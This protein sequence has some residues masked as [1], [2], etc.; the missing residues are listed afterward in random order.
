[1][2]RPW[3]AH[4]EPHV[5]KE[6]DP[7]WRRSIPHILEHSFEAFADRP[8][9][10]SMGV[11]LSYGEMDRLSAAFAAYLQRDLGLQKG[12]R[13]ALMMPNIL[14]YP[15]ALFG[16]LRA[17][18]IA[19][20]VNP[21]YT[22]RELRHQLVDS[23][24]V[25]IVILANF[26]HTLEK[27]IAGT[28][29]KHVVVT[30]LGDLFPFLKRTIVNF[31]VKRVKKMVPPWNLEAETYAGALKRGLGADFE[32]LEIAPEDTAF[33]Q[34]T[35]GT[36][37]VSKGAELTHRNIVANVAQALHWIGG[38]MKEGEEIIMTPL[39]LYHIFSLTG[40]CFVFTA[41]GGLNVLIANPKDIPSFV[42]EMGQWR[43]T[44][45]TGV[46]TLYNA[47]LNHPDFGKL[48]LS[49][50]KWALGGGM[51]VQRPVAERWRKL[52][53]SPLIE[54]YGLTETSPGACFNPLSQ[55]VFN[56]YIGVPLPS[57]DVSI[58]DNEGRELPLGEAGELCIRGPQ[59]MKGYWNKP[60]ETARVFHE[61]GWFRSGDIAV[62]NEEGFLKIVDR[63][64]D[65]ILVSGF[66]VYPNEIE[67]VV[68]GH[69]GVL[70]AA[71]VGV[72]DEKSTEAVKLFVVK[73]DPALTAED[74][75]AHCRE[76]L[77]GYKRPRHIEF[78]ETLPKT[79]VG[80]ILRRALREETAG[81][82]ENP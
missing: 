29:V 43:F 36:T 10:A 59:V 46:N 35:G 70:E 45:M 61:D 73:K 31:V 11:T 55:K 72:P 14:Q 18:L 69:P 64:K 81:E 56:G 19:V 39:P 12:D 15:V 16:V 47:L 51:A 26:A 40:N 24:A 3:H 34:Y 4:Y 53:G 1:M 65:M 60:E 25:A 48:D 38:E 23:E 2:K 32:K 8:A 6:I 68:A 76:N 52:T 22:P 54:A 80:K 49:S 75:K 13:V 79:N 71:A 78:R 74:L 5:P 67:E 30:E 58:R 50:L 44:A 28:E 62:M 17:G 77:T 57:T 27:A 20:N 21:L 82:T 63:E 66:N 9:F 33:L 41:L 7:A 37:G 42:K